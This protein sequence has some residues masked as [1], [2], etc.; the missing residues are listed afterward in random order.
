M[1]SN[2]DKI[3]NMK[4]VIISGGVAVGKS[5][6]ISEVINFLQ[7][8]NIKYIHVPEYIDV[9]KDALD[10]LKKYLQKEISA[11]EFQTYVTSFFDEYL[12][13]IK[14]E[15]DEIIIFERCFDDGIVCFSTLDYI[16][17]NMTE[18]EYFKLYKY[19]VELDKKYNAPSYFTNDNKIFIP[20]KTEDSFRDGNIISSIITNKIAT[21][22]IIIGLYNNDNTCYE[23]M[24]KRNR[25]GEVETYT[26]ET[27]ADFNYIYKKLYK[28]IMEKDKIN[29]ISL[30][31]LMR[32]K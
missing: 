9:K 26:R 32:N 13:S 7:S 2:V 28:I 4:K 25:P 29:V 5:S 18:E 14:I 21:N 20:I 19:A 22:N 3:K 11:F 31:S 15:G 17:G 10:M 1:S 16:N 24:L 12:E 23:R 8:N 6:V 27:I 30:G